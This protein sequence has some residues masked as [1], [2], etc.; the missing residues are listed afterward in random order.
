MT[1]FERLICLSEWFTLI[2][3]GRER[4]TLSALAWEVARNKGQESCF[5][6][7]IIDTVFWYDPYHCRNAYVYYRSLR[8]HIHR[9]KQ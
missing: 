6:S 5:Y 2:T 4:M 7:K 9:S 3:F 1:T 8:I